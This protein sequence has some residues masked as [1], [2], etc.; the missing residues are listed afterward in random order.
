[1]KGTMKKLLFLILILASTKAYAGISVCDDGNGKV[2]SFHLRGNPVEG[3]EWYDNGQNIS[4]AQDTAI[5]TLLK[6]VPQRYLKMINGF[7]AEMSPQE[8]VDVDDAWAAQ[9]QAD[10]LSV[11]RA[12]AKNSVDELSP[13]GVRLRASLLVVLERFN[14]VTAAYDAII[15]CHVNNSTVGAIRTCVSAISPV[16]T[17]TANA[18][19]TAIKNKIYAGNADA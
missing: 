11:S 12:N 14:T 6:T 17:A 4:E 15:A 9:I 13:E 16:G 1:M 3:C 8:K 10:L 19:R 18:M 7:P 5:R 2:A